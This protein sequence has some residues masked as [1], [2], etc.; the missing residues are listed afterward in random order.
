M[1]EQALA[2][3]VA[4]VVTEL[5]AQLA[6]EIAP[7]LTRMTALEARTPRDG[8]DGAPG[9]N[10]RDGMPGPPGLNGRDGTDGRD[11]VP[12]PAGLNGL[13]G[14]PGT[15]GRDGRDGAPGMAGRDGVDGA[16]GAAG[17]DGV[18]GAPGAA[19]R[20]GVDG[21]PGAAGRDGVLKG[22]LV[23]K[24][25]DVRRYQLCW[26][27]GTPM[28]VVDEAG[29]PIESVIRFPV[30]IHQGV[31]R[32]ATPYEEDDEVTEKGSVWLAKR[33]TTSRPGE[34]ATD[35]QLIVKRGAEGPRGK[36]GDPGPAGRDLTQMDFQGRKW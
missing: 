1:T 19:G 30:P 23:V 9:V 14:K 7:L 28:T 36:P 5:R 16:P 3:I 20:D 10:G 22:G 26:S 6:T 32:D 2:A 17:R 24:R 25:L 31:W 8:L 29:T 21:A 13:D 18:D 11:G 12:G 35:W 33:D 27:D 15:D 4:G 34:G